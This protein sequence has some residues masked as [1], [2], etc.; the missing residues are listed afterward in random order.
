MRRSW[1]EGLQGRLRRTRLRRLDDELFHTLAG[2]DVPVV[3]RLL[4]GLSRVMDWSLGWWLIAA[5]LA[6]GGGGSGRRAAVRGLLCLLAASVTVNHPVKLLARR[7]RPDLGAVPEA[8]RIASEPGSWSFPSGH[9]IAAFSFATGA[10]LEAPRAAVPLA[11]LA[12]AVGVSR[13]HNGAH[14]PSDVLAG[15]A[16]GTGVGLS[17]L[18]ARGRGATVASSPPRRSP[19]GRGRHT[20]VEDVR[21]RLPTVTVTGERAVRDVWW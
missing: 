14:Y 19:S 3:D 8:R 6:L 20:A 9:T 1:R 10:G 21:A 16:L 17:S 15:A 7:E 11:L 18:L 5:L 12:T 2:L 4:P 13:V